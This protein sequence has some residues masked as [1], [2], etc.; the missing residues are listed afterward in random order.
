FSVCAVIQTRNGCT[1]CF[2]IGG[3]LLQETDLPAGRSDGDE[4][5]LAN[6][7][8]DELEQ[9]LSCAFQTV[10]SEMQIVDVK[11]HGSSWC[12][13]FECLAGLTR[14]PVRSFAGHTARRDS[15]EEGYLSLGLI[16]LQ[17]ELLGFQTV[18]E[19]AVFVED[20]YVRLY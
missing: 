4:V 20:R 18:D 3:Q 14:F 8:I 19:A 9:R 13:G 2:F 12:I 7:A 16:D 15:F 10:G 6:A 1:Q 17:H 11:D 5:V